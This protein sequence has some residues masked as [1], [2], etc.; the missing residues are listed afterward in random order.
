MKIYN[1]EKT[2][3]LDNIDLSKGYLI[4]DKIIINTIPAQEAIKQQSHYEV[5]RTVYNDDGSI[6][7]KELK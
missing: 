5:I 4:K 7:G 3:I 1:K 6:K 2:Q